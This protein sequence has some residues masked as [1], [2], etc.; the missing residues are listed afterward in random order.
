MIKTPYPLTTLVITSILAPN[1]Y[2]VNIRIGML[3][4]PARQMANR[5]RKKS[6]GELVRKT[7]E[8]SGVKEEELRGGGQRRKVSDLRGKIA[9]FLNRE[10]GISMA[11]IGRNLG[12][13]TSAIAMAI[14]KIERKD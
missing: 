6:I 7:C 11:E 1:R 12:V 10:M 14:R 4:I 2:P 9:Y 3:I 13:S 8:E 5:K